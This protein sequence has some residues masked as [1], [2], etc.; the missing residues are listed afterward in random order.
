MGRNKLQKGFVQVYTGNGKGK[1]TAAI[2]QVIRAA[3]FGYKSYFLMLMKE[4]PYNEIKSLER[5][6]DLI[7][8]VQV[9]KDDF[10]YKKE[11]P[12]QEEILKIRNSLDL[13]TKKM[14]S[15]KYDLLVLD[16]VFV[17]IFFGL[18]IVDDVL[19]IIKQKPD[20]VELILT[21]RYCPQEIID[22][23]DLVTEM[24]EIKHYYQ[25]GIL[26]RRGIES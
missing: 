2:G 24:K 23:T 8:V 10:V 25:K 5:L 19:K 15:H 1:T 4:F 11:L 26:S 17:S 20:D 14:L 3:G 22:C 21:G 13:F 18:I 16:E 7:E 12:S 9:G 6:E